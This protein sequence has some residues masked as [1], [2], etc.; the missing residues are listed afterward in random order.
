[1]S[2]KTGDRANKENGW[3][4]GR[5]FQGR[6]PGVLPAQYMRVR[7]LSIRPNEHFVRDRGDDD[8]RMVDAQR[9]QFGDLKFGHRNGE[10]AVE[11]RVVNKLDGIRNPAAG[12][13]S[14]SSPTPSRIHACGFTALPQTIVTLG[15]V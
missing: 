14:R 2:S 4:G 6:G 11:P 12:S 13:G 10:A 8:R 5:S 9:C 1:M 15:L 3:A 7:H